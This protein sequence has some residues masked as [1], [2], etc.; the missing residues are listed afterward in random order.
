MPEMERKLPDVNSGN[1]GV[2]VEREKK[3]GGTISTQT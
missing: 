1:E 2:V 3:G